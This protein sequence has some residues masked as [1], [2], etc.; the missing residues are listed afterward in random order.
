VST[1][2]PNGEAPRSDTTAPREPTG[3]GRRA[4]LTA[5]TA[6]A[7]GAVGVATARP[8][9]AVSTA[10]MTETTTAASAA[11]ALYATASGSAFTVYQKGSGNG[12]FLVSD[13]TIGFTGRTLAENSWG[14]LVQNAGSALGNGGALRVEGRQNVGVFADTSPGADTVPALMGVGGDEVNGMALYTKGANILDGDVYAL[15]SFVGGVGADGKLAYWPTASGQRADHDLKG[16]TT[17]DS[18]G[19]GTVTLP[20]AYLRVVDATTLLVCLTPVGAAMPNLHVVAAPTTGSSSFQISGGSAG[21]TVHYSVSG[22]RIPVTVTSTASAAGTKV[23]T[24]AAAESP[25][26]RARPSLTLPD[27]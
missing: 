26:V 20:A 25:S 22:E 9:Q 18:S 14:G 8:A 24:L 23:K 10:L 21:G 19:A 5:G 6:A 27:R 16:R 4:V 13:T 2:R 12:S 11:T 7:L 15:R 3:R 1:T 17:L